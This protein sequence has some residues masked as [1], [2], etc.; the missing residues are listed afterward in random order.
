MKGVWLE[1]LIGQAKAAFPMILD[2]PGPR[3]MPPGWV[4][5]WEDDDW[6][7]KV[8]FEHVKRKHFEGTE[9]AGDPVRK[10]HYAIYTNV[11]SEYIIIFALAPD[12]RTQVQTAQCWK[13]VG[14]LEGDPRAP[15]GIQDACRRGDNRDPGDP[16]DP[17]AAPRDPDA[18]PQWIPVRRE[19]CRSGPDEDDWWMLRFCGENW[20]PGKSMCA[21]QDDLAFPAIM[22]LYTYKPGQDCRRNQLVRLTSVSELVNQAILYPGRAERCPFTGQWSPLSAAKGWG[23]GE[24][25]GAP[26][27][28]GV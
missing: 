8:V 2:E 7:S 23:K 16:R 11:F 4:P 1:G 17:D 5:F 6:M 14:F 21:M 15:R 22:D 10:R 27:G 28:W 12:P 9:L 25:K 3:K 24:G 26:W 13:I 19:L 18:A 20:Y